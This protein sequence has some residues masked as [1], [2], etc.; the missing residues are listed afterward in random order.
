MSADSNIDRRSF[1]GRLTKGA[2]AAAAAGVVWGGFVREAKNAPLCLRPPGALS[3]P[4]FL[5][6]CI[7]CGQCVE[8]CPYDTLELA[9]A[10]SGAPAG[11][12][13]FEPRQVPCYLCQDIPC[14]VACPTGAL[15]TD[16]VGA[17]DGSGL[18][19][20]RAR[21]GIA[22]MDFENCI[23]AWGLRCDACYRVCPLIDK[24]I[25]IEHSRNQRTGR[26]AV[27]LPRVQA[28]ACTGCGLCERACVVE[29]A[30]IFVLPLD[31]AQGQVGLNYRKGW[32][33]GDETELDEVRG[34]AADLEPGSDG[35]LDYL[36]SG[37][38]DDD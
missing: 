27:L 7:R 24:A 31:V 15:A 6:K 26:H 21:M 32:E 25:I 23:A 17:E 36:N 5:G 13:R 11:T 37:G 14:T 2:A 20:N 35:A 3:E 30:A 22:V 10:G 29:K 4:D 38:L 34:P 12:P 9:D 28:D 8:A 1:L 18:D 19:V 33:P 16:L